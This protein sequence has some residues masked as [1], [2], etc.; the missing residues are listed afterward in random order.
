MLG[1]MGIAI[2]DWAHHG[3]PDIFVT[4]W[5][6]QE[7]AL[8]ENLRYMGD[9]SKNAGGMFFGDVADTVGLGQISKSYIGWGTSFFT[10]TMT[11]SWICWL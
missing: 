4:H 3:A 8:F 1:A 2:G 7:N 10:T 9:K 11:A 5:V 6:F